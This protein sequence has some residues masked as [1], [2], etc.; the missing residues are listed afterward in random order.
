MLETKTVK[1]LQSRPH[2]IRV[3]IFAVT[4][5]TAG[6][7]GLSFFVSSLSSNFIA[8]DLKKANEE[9]KVAEVTEAYDDNSPS[10]F[11]NLK[12]N[13]QDFGSAVDSIFDRHSDSG[14]DISIE[15]NNEVGKV[16]EKADPIDG[17]AKDS[18]EDRANNQV[19]A[20]SKN[21]KPAQL[22]VDQQ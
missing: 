6:I 2:H 12:A 21:I 11:E 15:K 20:G 1:Y 13:I 3:M 22:P 16:I 4:M 8:A 17:V 7:L 5:F 9:N 18:L 19:Q 14:Q 10:I